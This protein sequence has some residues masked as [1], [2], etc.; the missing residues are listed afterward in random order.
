MI[1]CMEML[2]NSNWTELDVDMADALT[3]KIGAMVMLTA[4]TS[5]MKIICYV[6]R[7]LKW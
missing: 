3:R 2:A 5:R 7:Q 6:S 4:T 1:W